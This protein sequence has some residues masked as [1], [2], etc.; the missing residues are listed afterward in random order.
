MDST[1]FSILPPTGDSPYVLFVT[2][3]MTMAGPSYALFAV[4]R[5]QVTQDEEGGYATGYLNDAVV[6]MFPAGTPYLLVPRGQYSAQSNIEAAREAKEEEDALKELF[7][8]RKDE[9]G[10]LYTGRYE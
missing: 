9:G 1:V 10:K 5:V 4:D 6:T 7:K 8:D 2:R 3:G